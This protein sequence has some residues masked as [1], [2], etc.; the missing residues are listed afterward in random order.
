MVIDN[1]VFSEE[2]SAATLTVAMLPY[3][4]YEYEKSYSTA[5]LLE[6]AVRREFSK[7]VRC[8]FLIHKPTKYTTD[9]NTHPDET[10]LLMQH[11]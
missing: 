1:I 11:H 7:I 2:M 4:S 8:Y 10:L 9:E 6:I 5:D 3:L